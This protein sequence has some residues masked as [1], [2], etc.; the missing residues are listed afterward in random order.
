ML[1][2]FSAVA[3]LGVVPSLV[4]EVNV[5]PPVSLVNLG[6][7]RPTRGVRSPR[8]QVDAQSAGFGLLPMPHA[9]LPLPA[10]LLVPPHA[11][12][13]SLLHAGPRTPFPLPTVVSQHAWRLS[14]LLQGS[15]PLLGRPASFFSSSGFPPFSWPAVLSFYLLRI[16]PR[17]TPARLHARLLARARTTDERTMRRVRSAGV[18]DWITALQ[19]N[20][21][22]T[23]TAAAP[24]TLLA[25]PIATPLQCGRPKRSGLL[26]S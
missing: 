16:A 6:M 7:C 8:A 18:A 17:A 11:H 15:H 24:P 4:P 22:R 3:T 10:V 23:L 25:T 20:T 12:S 14:F 13:A 5:L 2:I 26:V 19:G 21:E 1:M 9:P